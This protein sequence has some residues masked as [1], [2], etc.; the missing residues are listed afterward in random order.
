[1]AWQSHPLLVLFVLGGF[2]ALGVTAYCG[3]RVRRV[4][5]GYLVV[6]VGLLGLANTVWIFAAALKTAS[7][8]LAPK[9]LFYKLQFLG[10][11]A[12]P[13]LGV[14][15][16]LAFL[17]W[18]RRL[19]TRIVAGLAVGSLLGF[20]LV[21]TNPANAAIAAPVVVRSQGIRV[22]EHAFP[23]LFVLVL[24]WALGLATLTALLFLYGAVRG[25]VPRKPAILGA[26]VF[27]L[28][29]L[30]IS[31]KLARIYPPGGEGINLTPAADG[32]ALGLLA[33]GIVRYR[34][35]E[36]VPIGRDRAVEVMPVGYL[37]AGPEDRVLDANRA[38]RDLVGRGGG[39]GLERRPVDEVVPVAETLDGESTARFEAAGRTIRVRS[40]PVARG[41]GR[42][43][44]LLLLQDVT[45]RLERERALERSNERLDRFAGVL[46]HDLRNPLGVAKARLQLAREEA[47]SP[48]FDAIEQSHDR[49]QE[50]ID[51]ALSLARQGAAVTETER[52]ALADLS[53]STWLNVETGEATLRTETDAV[54]RADVHRLQRLLENLFRNAVEHGGD[55]VTVTV[56][57]VADAFYVQDDGPGIP[58][59]DR[60]DVFETGYTSTRNGTGFGLS[61]VEAIAEAHGWS[62]SVTAGPTGG[63]RVQIS[64]VDAVDP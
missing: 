4:G 60:E 39:A 59:A 8:D 11:L 35:L 14:I 20:V 54:V 23:P 42:D 34:F 30:I 10:S 19:T 13:A 57:T 47:D 32:I 7:T 33:V 37:L 46:S 52:V 5:A 12:A 43:G 2:V 38:A 45:E 41:S 22:L 1:M 62:V 17:G 51:D 63:A 29:L 25:V 58:E 56:G 24:A 53:E 44:R 55:D 15:I 16:A 36:L 49:I 27:A 61:I 40:S 21:A 64:G 18:H 26:A 48:H 50:L 28:P 31:L 9:L 3:D 6:A